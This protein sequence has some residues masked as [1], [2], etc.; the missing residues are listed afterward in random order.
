MPVNASKK[1]K[2][3]LILPFAI[4]AKNRLKDFTKNMELA[5]VLYLAEANRKKGEHRRLKKKEEKLVFIAE[6]CYPIWLV[7]YNK[8]TLMFDGLSLVSH[9]LFCDVIPDVEIFNKDI[10]RNQKTT[11]ALIAALT[12]NIDYFSDFQGK[13]EIKIEGLITTPALKK[14]L[15]NY[16][17]NMK[18]SR[19]P[20]A[21]TVFLKPIAKKHEIKV[22]IKQLSNLKSRIA[23]EIDDIDASMKLLNVTTAQRVK[24][25]RE[26]IKK[27]RKTHKKQIKK[28]KIETTKSLQQIQNQ[29]NRLIA[30]TSKKYKRRLLQLNKNQIKL[31]KALRSLR[32]EAK[33]CET[34]I[35]SSKRQNR[36]RKERQW[37]T[38]LERIKKRV[39]TLRKEIKVNSKRIRDFN[40]KQK[41]ELAK[42][43]IACCKRIASANKQFL[44]REGSREAEILMK[45]Q[46]I[47]TIEAIT[48]TITKSMQ[49]ML[50]KKRLFHAEFERIA[51]PRGK[52]SHR[53]V[54]MPF[55]LARYEKEDK[56]RY[57]VY[58]PSI[59]GNMGALTK[60]KGALGVT[61]VKTLIQ[62]RSEATAAFLNQL[63]VFFEKKP[64][65]EKDVTES[66]IQKSILL[67]KKLRVGVTKGLKKLQNENWISKKELQAFRKILYTYAPSMKRNLNTILIS[68]NNYLKCLPA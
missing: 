39:K 53:L 25:I 52:K 2:K 37:T 30:R 56:R 4:P 43:R 38:K 15:R 31:R 32:K 47:A 57:F 41:R 26:E 23:K 61:K 35:K 64:M 46:E 59:V 13:E 29:Y 48:R 40:N 49:T 7:P 11:E 17:Q 66:G 5:A 36:K 8:A 6:T 10:R 28:A 42:H 60:M 65:L 33:R 51:I 12:R 9:T 63:P 1:P 20:S 22:G 19:K 54:Y 24:A 67:R 21:N 18:E 44:D 34:K 45:S 27:T 68:E 58:P 50:Q 16:F 3:R 62:P 14:D 55:Y